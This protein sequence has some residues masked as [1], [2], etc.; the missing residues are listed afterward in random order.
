MCIY[1]ESYKLTEKLDAQFYI[2]IYAIVTT[3]NIT[4]MMKERLKMFFNFEEVIEK[5][6]LIRR[7]IGC[8]F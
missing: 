7:L 4:I 1:V 2:C 6:I 3:T 5:L 8:H